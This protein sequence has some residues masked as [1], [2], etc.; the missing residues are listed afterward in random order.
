MIEKVAKNAQEQAVGAIIEQIVQARLEDLRQ[1]LEYQDLRFEQALQLVAEC[2]RRIREEVVERGF[3]RGGEKGMH[4]FIAE[5]LEV[6][7]G[8]ARKVMTGK[9]ADMFLDN[10][11]GVADFH[12]GNAAY[13]SKFVLRYLGMDSLIAHAEK[14]PEFVKS[15]G[16][17]SLASDLYERLAEIAGVS[18]TDFESLTS[19]EQT[20][21][22][23]AQRLR[24]VGIEPGKN[25]EPSAFGFRDV[26]R[27]NYE[28]TI[29][30]E[31]ESIRKID[32]EARR[33]IEAD[34]SPT[35]G[36]AAK[37]T[38]AGATLEAGMSLGLA[39]YRKIKGGKKLAEF[40]SDDWKDLGVEAAKG[41]TRGAFRGGAVYLLTTF[42]KLPGAAATA[43]VTATL[44]MGGQAMQLRAGS[45]TPSEFVENSEIL[46]LDSA[47]SALSA[48]MGQVLIPLPVLGALVG[49]VAGSL[50]YEISKTN[51]SKYE[52]DLIS[53]ALARSETKAQTLNDEYEKL[54]VQY[55]Q[56]SLAF[57]GSLEF[58]FSMDANTSLEASVEHARLL[59]VPEK[60]IIKSFEEGT[61]YFES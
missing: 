1:T 49:N 14:Y 60:S 13:Q 29:A 47:V 22:I 2:E 33:G 51:L 3:G 43:A 42:T 7:V 38:A 36:E 18:E 6:Y 19:V 12:V 48:L 4:G 61:A 27:E 44:G 26:R 56:R 52:Q 55:H 34:H 20:L 15:G 46:C 11:N 25:L 35:L 24:E 10:D 37:A 50:A 54:A 32:E 40:T 45:I 16:R 23:K 28:G 41:G 59:G 57:G 21:W 8:N 5:Y 58:A 9:I 31:R 30:R 39:A 53:G 17:Y